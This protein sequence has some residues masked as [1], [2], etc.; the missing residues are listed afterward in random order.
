MRIYT[1]KE[2]QYMID[3]AREDTYMMVPL[4]E[5]LNHVP[6]KP[7]ER[8]FRNLMTNFPPPGDMLQESYLDFWKVAVDARIKEARKSVEVNEAWI[9]HRRTNPVRCALPK[10]QQR[11]LGILPKL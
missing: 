1:F 9:Q 4:L 11:Q 2:V 10:K 7:S 5:T 3:R 8:E 6:F